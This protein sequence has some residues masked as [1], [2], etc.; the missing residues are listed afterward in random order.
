MEKKQPEP[1]K[2][3]APNTPS[4]EDVLKQIQELKEHNEKL[5]KEKN[6]L[7]N[8]LLNGKATENIKTEPPKEEPDKGKFAEEFFG[9][10]CKEKI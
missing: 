6:E 8:A 4:M 2:E 10:W 9:K 5:E 1:K 3:E 7:F